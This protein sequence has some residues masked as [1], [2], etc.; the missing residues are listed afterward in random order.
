[1]TWRG[2][3]SVRPRKDCT[4]AKPFT[5]TR[6]GFYILIYDPEAHWVKMNHPIRNHNGFTL[7]ELIVVIVL[8]GM[9]FTFALPKMDGL[10]YVNN[11]DRV[12]R[13]VIVKVEQLK[14]KAVQR[15]V[16]YTLHVDI[17]SNMFWISEQGMDEE[18]LDK[19][20]K[21]GYK[22]PNDIRLVDII[23]PS[24]SSKDEDR[25]DVTFYPRGYS[26]HA[27]IHMQNDDE[28]KLSFVIE[29][30]LPPVGL[31]EGFVLFDE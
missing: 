24:Q 3:T 29:P 28:E 12:S 18:A 26:D 16:P 2:R 30:F 21:G 22:L 27:I 15:Q 6:Y 23:Y 7:V 11:R 20:Q 17:K 10:L 19:A 13:W 5:V 14:N 25:S 9:M 4:G 8:I 1:M 31:N